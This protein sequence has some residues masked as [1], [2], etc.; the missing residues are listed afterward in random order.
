MVSDSDK[1]SLI[2]SP[3][4]LIKRLKLSSRSKS[5]HA[6]Q[7]PHCMIHFR[8][9]SRWRNGFVKGGGALDVSALASGEMDDIGKVTPFDYALYSL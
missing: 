1:D 5:H 9:L 3:N 8:I 7:R 2:A 6:F 4:S